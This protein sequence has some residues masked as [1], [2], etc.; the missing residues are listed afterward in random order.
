MTNP[1]LTPTL[2]NAAGSNP[3][4]NEFLAVI[5]FVATSEGGIGLRN[6]QRPERWRVV[7]SVV[8]YAGVPDGAKDIWQ[9]DSGGHIFCQQSTQIGLVSRGSRCAP[10]NLPGVFSRVS[11]SKHWIDATFC[12]LSCSHPIHCG[13]S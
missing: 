11:S 2:V 6:V 4:N 7:D 8:L 3:V 10:E 13:G 5:A 1:N 12:G 9:G